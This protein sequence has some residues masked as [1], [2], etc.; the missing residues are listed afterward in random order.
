[1][2]IWRKSWPIKNIQGENGDGVSSK[3]KLLPDERS[4]WDDYLDMASPAYGPIAGEV[5][6]QKG[7][8]YPIDMLSAMLKTPLEVIARANKHMEELGMITIENSGVIIINKWA[9]YQSEYE[10]QKPYRVTEKVTQEGYKESNR[11][12]IDSRSNSKSIDNRK[13]YIRKVYIP[14]YTSVFNNWNSKK[15]TK[16]ALWVTHKYLTDSCY[17]ILNTRLDNGYTEAEIIQAI[18]NYYYILNGE[19]YFWSYRWTLEEFIRRGLDKFMDLETA[20]KNYSREDKASQE[21]DIDAE[22]TRL[23]KMRGKK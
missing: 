15:K 3:R 8:A 13:K 7:I 5:C 10:R 19:R 16:D 23:K 6:A 21:E 11:I 1:M 22:V 4:V 12:D 20:K 9:E 14:V 2:A 18:D 17:G